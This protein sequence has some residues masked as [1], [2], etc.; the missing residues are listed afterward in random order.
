VKETRR[1]Q[2]EEAIETLTAPLKRSSGPSPFELRKE[3]QELNWN[4]V[5]VVREEKGLSE[6]LSEIKAIT[7]ES[8]HM[9]VTGGMAYNMLFNFSLDLVSML[10][11]SKVVATSALM[12]DETRGAHT[13]Q[14]FPTQRDDYGLFNT[15]MHQD[16]NGQLV[17]DTKPVEFKYKSVE[18]CQQYKK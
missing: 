11:I 10:D 8:K 3:L 6:S 4:K 16:E 5:G 15:F 7:E 13:R 1:G 9:R 18:Q 17:T 14:D 2:V 12:R